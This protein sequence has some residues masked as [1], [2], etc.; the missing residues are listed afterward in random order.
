MK[1]RVLILLIAVALVLAGCMV[2]LTRNISGRGTVALFDGMLADGTFVPGEASFSLNFACYAQ[3]NNR[4]EGELYWNDPTNGVRISA[5][6]PE[7]PVRVVTGGLFTTC[8]QMKAAA[9]YLGFSLN[10]A[11]IFDEDG[12]ADGDAGTLV[13][14]AGIVVTE[15]GH[16]LIN[17]LD[18][19]QTIPNPCGPEGTA[20]F[21]GVS[22]VDIPMYMAMGCLNR[23]Q[24]VFR[25]TQNE[26]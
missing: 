8:K 1:K 26:Q 3:N 2:S 9:S 23:G 21:I 13:G 22:S 25:N 7:T 11:G 10:T 6:L 4:V 5:T 20:V 14:E 12:D 18:P 24:I 19:S 15:P 17:P 16:D